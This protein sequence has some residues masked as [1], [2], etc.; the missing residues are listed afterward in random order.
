MSGPRAVG[1]LFT[2]PQP[3]KPPDIHRTMKPSTRSA[4]MALVTGLFLIGACANSE[5]GTTPGSGG[6]N[7]PGTAGTTGSAGTNGVAG[8]TGTAGTTGS[9]GTT[10]TAGTTTAGSAGT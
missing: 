10:G 4:S 7:G 1:D 6:A 9:A 5:V 8:T 3:S 2:S